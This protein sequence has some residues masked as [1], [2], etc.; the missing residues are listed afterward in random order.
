MHTTSSTQ[1]SA[2]GN[3]DSCRTLA[4]PDHPGS[5]PTVRSRV[6]IATIPLLLWGGG[7]LRINYLGKIL[8]IES[9]ASPLSTRR[10][11]HSAVIQG[12]V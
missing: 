10:T 2:L 12:A 11:K 9:K 5:Q 3:P 7:L 4:V 8:S 1:S 6:S